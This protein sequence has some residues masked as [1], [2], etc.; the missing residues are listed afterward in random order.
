MT[1]QKSFIMD[2]SLTTNRPPL[3]EDTTYLPE[4][5]SHGMSLDKQLRF[6]HLSSFCSKEVEEAL[7]LNKQYVFESRTHGAQVLPGDMERDAL[8]K[9]V[10]ASHAPF[11]VENDLNTMTRRPHLTSYV[12]PSNP[13]AQLTH[14]PPEVVGR[15]FKQM[16]DSRLAVCLGLTC[17]SFYV[18]HRSVYRTEPS[19][20]VGSYIDNE[21][22][23]Q[24]FEPMRLL[25]RFMAA[26]EETWNDGGGYFWDEGESRFRKRKTTQQFLTKWGKIFQRE[27]ILRPLVCGVDT[28]EKIRS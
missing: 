8:L 10:T 3:Q 28:D 7:K 19:L 13:K 21:G 11:R 1:T 18:I 14:L 26:S 15:I 23:R 9:E 27:L 25:E 4:E 24:F 16:E 2:E 20:Q 22:N 12:S 5:Y 6:L 17:R